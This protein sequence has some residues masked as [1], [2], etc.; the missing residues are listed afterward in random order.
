[1]D[2]S[3][4]ERV[5]K[6]LHLLITRHDEKCRA[7]EDER[8][9]EELGV[10]VLEREGVGRIVPRRTRRCLWPQRASSTRGRGKL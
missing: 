3:H 6:E 1:V 10:E 2:I 7:E 5:E 9:A 8:P 4:G